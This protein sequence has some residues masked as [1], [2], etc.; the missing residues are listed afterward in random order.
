MRTSEGWVALLE[1]R[2]TDE[3][4]PHRVINASIS[5]ETSSGGLNRFPGVLRKHQPKI[6]IIELG[7]NDGLRGL[8]LTLMRKNLRSMINAAQQ[9]NARVLLLG[10]RLPPNYGPRYTQGF[11]QVFVEL[12]REYKTGLV[13]FLLTGVATQARLMQSDGLH[14][15]AVAQ[16]RILDTVW[17]HLQPLLN[18][19][20]AAAF[21]VDGH[22]E[23]GSKNFDQSHRLLPQ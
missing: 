13:P 15:T 5:G 21:Q 20:L 2:L 11:A 19:T 23:N 6:V 18:S 1:K 7:A 8:P 3:H 4:L 17:P 10:M 16:S 14:P 12:A 9:N 22:H